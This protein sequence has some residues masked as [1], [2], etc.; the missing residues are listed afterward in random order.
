MLELRHLDP[1][2][3]RWAATERL[4]PSSVE[5]V[6]RDRAMQKW[7]H[8]LL[9][10]YGIVS[11]E[12]LKLEAGAPKWKDLRRAFVRLELLAEARRGFFVEGL[13]GEQYAYPQAV[14]SLREAKLRQPDT[15]R[16]RPWGHVEVA[17]A[18]SAMVVVNMCDPANPFNRLFPLLTQSGEELRSQRIPQIYLVLEAGRPLLR[19]AGHI[20]VLVDLTRE[21]A[22]MAL[23]ALLSL[24]DQPAPM[25]PHTE[26]QVRDW[27]G[28]PI[29]VSSARHLLLK[30]GFVPVSNR[31]KGFV[32][33]GV[34]RPDPQAVSEA[35]QHIPDI[36]EHVG[37]EKAPVQYDAE[38]IISRSNE[39]IRPKVRELLGF[40]Q[41]ELPSECEIV[42]DPRWFKV[43]YRGLKCMWSHIQ[44]RQVNLH[45]AHRGWVPPIQ[46]RADTDLAS[47]DFTSGF[48]S[49][50]DRSRQA[51]DE[52]LAKKRQ[53]G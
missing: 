50:F 42:Y 33:D 20:T 11:R 5:D 25:S 34:A 7:A 16:R 47:A 31:W 21:R 28:H 53:L 24:V 36:F 49:Q 27:N 23:A 29:D 43:H 15:N 17:P 39:A 4:L 18:D 12:A 32:Y 37:K 38:W 30:L 19:Y 10:R 45:I 14:E 48:S 51:I 41:Q 46:I 2:L 6:D 44:Q 13:S 3:G 22:E 26:I 8:L 40:L 1:R 52:V 9:R 35:E